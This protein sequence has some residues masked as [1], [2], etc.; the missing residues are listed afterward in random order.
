VLDLTRKAVLRAQ[1][2]A[3]E[4][5]ALEPGRD[6]LVLVPELPEGEE[7]L[8]KGGLRALTGADGQCGR[9]SWCLTSAAVAARVEG[10][11]LA[12]ACRERFTD[13]H[14]PVVLVPARGLDDEQVEVLVVLAVD[15]LERGAMPGEGSRASA[16]ALGG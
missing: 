2:K 7:A 8:L 14:R 11:A 10:G 15:A 16:E 1:A 9:W 5:V 3:A 4:L 6:V 12:W 13:E